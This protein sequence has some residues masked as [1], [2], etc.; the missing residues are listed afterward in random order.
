MV[1]TSDKVPV[2]TVKGLCGWEKKHSFLYFFP[3][4]SQVEMCRLINLLPT[5]LF[6]QIL[7][8][9]GMIT[10]YYHGDSQGWHHYPIIILLL[11]GVFSTR[12]WTAAIAVALCMLH[13]RSLCFVLRKQIWFYF[14]GFGWVFMIDYIITKVS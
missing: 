8:C 5:W 6:Q 2:M 4:L 1:I 7:A 13:I 12:C 14:L 10:F 3:I 9:I 11:V